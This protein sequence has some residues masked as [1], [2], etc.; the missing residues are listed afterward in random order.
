ML[1]YLHSLMVSVDVKHQVDLL[2]LLFVFFF[3]LAC[4]RIFIK[5]RTIGSRCVI[6]QENVLFTGA[7][8]HLSTRTFYRLGQ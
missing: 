6:G 2:T 5:T 4:E 8:V 1:T 7:S 3:A